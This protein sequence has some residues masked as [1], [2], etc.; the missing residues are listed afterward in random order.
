M[1]S[2]FFHRAKHPVKVH[3]WAGISWKGRTPIVIFDGILNAV[4][5]ITI[6][7][8]ALIP[9]LDD[10]Y[11]SGHRL[12]MDNDPKHTSNR[13]SQYLEEKRINW[14]HTPAESPD[15]NPIE[16][17]WHEL[18]EY[19]RREVKPSG[20]EEL[21][22]GIEKFWET[23]DVAKCQKY[24]RHLRKVVPKVVECNGGPTGY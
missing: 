8:S 17:M 16:N 3:V 20:K 21:I 12:M 14:W 15:L 7:E 5:F 13:V 2:D 22:E 19:I 1:L 9:F 18:K 24:I 23:V 6:L 4:G 11:P 10:V